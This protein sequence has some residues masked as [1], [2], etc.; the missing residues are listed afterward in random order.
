MSTGTS[1]LSRPQASVKS[2]EPSTKHR[3]NA[4]PGNQRLMLKSSTCGH[5]V[6]PRS[7][8]KRPQGPRSVRTFVRTIVISKGVSSTQ[9]RSKELPCC[10][11]RTVEQAVSRS[12]HE[13]LLLERIADPG[14]QLRTRAPHRRHSS[15]CSTL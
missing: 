6:V 10:R 7:R 9:R 11:C 8:N 13:H 1:C 4:N 12:S 2:R 5:Y 3:K 15:C 14:A